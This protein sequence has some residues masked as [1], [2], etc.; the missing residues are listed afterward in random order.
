[1]D[2]RSFLFAS[3]AA[4]L[5]AVLLVNTGCDQPKKPDAQNSQ[6]PAP[7]AGTGTG[8]TGTPDLKTLPTDDGTAGRPPIGG[9]TGASGGTRTGAGDTGTAP[10]GGGKVHVMKPHDT[11]IALARL[12]YGPD[13]GNKANVKKIMDANPQYPDASKIPVGAKINIP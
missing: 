12:Y 6:I 5:L 4:C 13:Q 10:L 9:G 11:I 1:M 3:A 8:S 7:T 2:A